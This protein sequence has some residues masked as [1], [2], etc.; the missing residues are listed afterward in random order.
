MTIDHTALII[1]GNRFPFHR[2]E[3][4]GP[5]IARMIP[6]TVAPTLTTDKDDLCDL[7]GFDIVVDYLGD[8]TLTDAQRNGLLSFVESGGSYLGLHCAADLTSVVPTDT[9]EVID[10]NDEP[11]SGLRNLIGGHFRTHPAQTTFDVRIVDHY[12][13]VTADLSDMRV[14]DEPYVLDVDANVRVLARMDHPEYADMPVV[15][16]R[17]YGDGQVFYCSLGHDE[18][19]LVHDGVCG[20]LNNAVRWLT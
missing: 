8:S 18:A 7:S 13:P 16:I 19:T 4:N 10:H 14:H 17:E 6:E 3:T 1:G 12:H 9:S 20:L 15:W 11:F 2:F 5:L